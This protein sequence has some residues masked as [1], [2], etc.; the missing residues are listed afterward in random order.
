M[1]EKSAKRGRGEFFAID[2][3]TWARACD[4]GMNPAVAYLV[5]AC[6]S[7]R[8]N[9]HTNASVNA[10]EKHTGIARSRAREALLQLIDAGFVRQTHSGTKPRY[11]LAA[12]AE[13]PGVMPSPDELALHARIGEGKAP[14]L[15]QHAIAE[16][17]LKRGWATRMEP[18]GPWHAKP[19]PSAEPEPVWLPNALVT[20]AE[21]EASPVERV[22]QTTD[23]MCLR[24]LVDLYSAQN[25]RDDGGVSRKVIYQKHERTKVGECGEYIVWG[26][27]AVGATYTKWGSRVTDAHYREPTAEEKKANPNTNTAVDF[28]KRL[29]N[30]ERLG[31]IDWT[32]YLCESEAAGAEIIHPLRFPGRV[33]SKSQAKLWSLEERLAMAADEAGSRL[34][35]HHHPEASDVYLVPVLRHVE[36]VAVVGVARLHYRPRTRNTSEWWATMQKQGPAW[37]AK[38]DALGAAPAI[39]C[40]SSGIAAPCNINGSQ[41]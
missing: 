7:A 10:I 35:N 36:R 40:E 24:L 3:R 11:E 21:N 12:F 26:F 39:P 1:S 32:P 29:T 13:L 5:L 28:F 17:L 2:A 6:F 41:L 18:H 37:V 22:R 14:T 27:N 25:L 4:L 16:R 38:Y 33:A 30:L 34:L 31:L 9:A 20:G 19:L 23:A 15:Q 8:D